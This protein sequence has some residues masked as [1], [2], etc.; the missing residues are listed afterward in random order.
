MLRVEMLHQNETHTGIERQI[1]EQFR[2]R[3]QPAGGSAN[4]DDGKV[5]WRSALSPVS[6]DL[7]FVAPLP[8]RH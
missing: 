3:L 1:L 8:P 7:D 6:F 4:A 2:E 5:I